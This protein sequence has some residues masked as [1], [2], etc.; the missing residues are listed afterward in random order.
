MKLY[1]MAYTDSAGVTHAEWFGSKAEGAKR[2]NE[3]REQ[4]REAKARGFAYDETEVDVPKG[5][6]ELL[7]FLTELTGAGA[8]TWAKGKIAAAVDAVDPAAYS[9]A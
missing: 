3:L 4:I 2:R 1:K 6:K 9:A 8:P 7:A 5:K